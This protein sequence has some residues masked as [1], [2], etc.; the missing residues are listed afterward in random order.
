MAGRKSKL[1]SV[2]KHIIAALKTGA[3]DTDVCTHVGISQSTFY[4][5]LE[6]GAAEPDSQFSEFSDAVTRARVAA[7]VTAIG[8]LHT[9]MMP[10]QTVRRTKHT[11]T[12]TRQNQWGKEFLYVKTDEDELTILNPGDWRAAV[13]YLKRRHNSEWGDK[14]TSVTMNVEPSLLAKVDE[15]L[16]RTG[17]T[18]SDIFEAMIQ[19]A[20]DDSDATTIGRGDVAETQGQSPDR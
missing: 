8:T 15:L 10:T 17:G 19:A 3:T 4:L 6:R 7:K 14:S 12:E 2:Q 5:W 1:D 16:K 18:L 11:V 20:A 13:E 9:A